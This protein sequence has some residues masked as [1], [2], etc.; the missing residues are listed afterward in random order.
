MRK[1][2]DISVIVTNYNNSKYIEECLISLKAQTFKNFE[3][4]VIDDGSADNSLEIINKCISG[5]DRFRLFAINHIGFP[6]AKNVGL[7][8]AIGDYI[9]FLD[10]DDSAYPYWLQMLYE[11]AIRSNADITACLFDE[12][13]TKKAQEP[14]F[15]EILS[16]FNL[17]EY[18]WLKMPLL[19]RKDC[20]S[21]MWNKLIRRELYDGIRHEDQIALSDVSVMYKLFDK[22]NEVIQIMLPLVH[23]RRHEQSMT[24]ETPKKGDEY[25][26][27]R[28]NLFK[29]VLSFIYKKYP[30]ARNIC[31]IVMVKE[32]MTAKKAMK[33]NFNLLITTED[34]NDI[35]YGSCAKIFL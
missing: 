5:D 27:F 8:N 28:V 33:D 1:K 18:S 13:S 12:Y 24:A 9:I 19:F 21:F 31:N 29:K 10:A 20:M 6:L 4:L 2:P 11:I 14:S 3:A 22:A 30:Q 34:I 7:D 25:W 17:R 32:L 15:S 26:V 16:H 35:L 23:Y